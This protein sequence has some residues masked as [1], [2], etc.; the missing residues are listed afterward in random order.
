V[1]IGVPSDQAWTKPLVNASDADTLAVVEEPS[2]PRRTGHLGRLGR[3]GRLGFWLS[4]VNP[5]AGG[6][7]LFASVAAAAEA[8]EAAGF[9]SLWVSD[10]VRGPGAVSVADPAFEAYSLLG[11]LATRTRRIRLGALPTAADRRA[12]SVLAKIVTGLDVISHGRSTASVRLDVGAGPMEVERTLEAIRV[13]RAVLDD[14]QPVL[15]GHYFQIDGAVNQPRPVQE[16]GIPLVVILQAGEAGQTEQTG[17]PGQPDQ[18]SQT[19]QL[20]KS[21]LQIEALR[22]VAGLADALV[23]RGGVAAVEDAASASA[24][25]RVI[26]AGRLLV[27][28]DGASPSTS[29]HA[30]PGVRPSSDEQSSQAGDLVGTADEVTGQ[31]G[32]LMRAGADGCIVSIVSSDP[33]GSIARMGPILWRAVTGTE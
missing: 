16:G 24:S 22:K 9:D 8:A 3:L 30:A 1:P 28:T 12:P 32:E 4:P 2:R 14:P 27:D 23:V 13:C 10:Q 33:L 25:G 5:A 18:V 11:A 29:D 6:H 17:Q 31:L 21:P 20:E 26:W 15:D 19:G 7:Q